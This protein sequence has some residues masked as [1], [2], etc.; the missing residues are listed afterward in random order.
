MISQIIDITSSVPPYEQLRR[1]IAAQIEAGE[2]EAD[3][4]LPTVRELARQMGL[5]NNTV[6]RTYRELESAGYIRT[7]GRRGTFVAAR[8]SPS[9]EEAR[10]TADHDPAASCTSN[11]MALLRPEAYAD[12]ARLD[13]WIH[14]HFTLVDSAGNVL[15]R[16]AA[17]DTMRSEAVGPVKVEDL[18]T[19]RLGPSVL[20]L[21]YVTRR[22]ARASR[23]STVWVAQVGGWR[24]RWRQT[25]PI[26]G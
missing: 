12:P 1:R 13:L 11:E 24:C 16:Q 4:R 25:T 8:P 22:G 18:R 15:A 14:E 17:L 2:L 21:S 23:H 5:A 9:A 7:E 10:R 19:E 6:A 26:P 3:R 20:V